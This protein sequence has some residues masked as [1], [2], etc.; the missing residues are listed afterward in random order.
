MLKP[1]TATTCVYTLALT[2]RPKIFRV[3]NSMTDLERKGTIRPAMAQP[4]RETDLREEK[5]AAN[6]CGG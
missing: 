5:A 1:T 3:H 4:G 6:G 2:H